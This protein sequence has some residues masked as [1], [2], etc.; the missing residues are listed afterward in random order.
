MRARIRAGLGLIPDLAAILPGLGLIRAGGR[1]RELS[2]IPI[3]S[4]GQ[5]CSFFGTSPQC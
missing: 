5:L 4:T 2:I 1:C 3:P